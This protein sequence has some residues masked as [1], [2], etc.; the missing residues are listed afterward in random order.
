[1]TNKIYM[2]AMDG[3]IELPDHLYAIADESGKLFTTQEG[4]RITFTHDLRKANLYAEKDLAN[5]MIQNGN[6]EQALIKQ[7]YKLKVVPVLKEF[8]LA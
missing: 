5:G 8:K 2:G 4:E 1:M 6:Y 3:V 7:G